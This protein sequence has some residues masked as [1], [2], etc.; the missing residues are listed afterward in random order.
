MA[1]RFA[2]DRKE[3]KLFEGLSRLMGAVIVGMSEH[4]VSAP[5]ASYLVRNQSRF[6]F[7]EEFAYVPI[8]EMVEI[9]EG[10]GKEMKMSVHC[11][12]NGC[13]YSSQALHYL[14][15]PKALKEDLCMLNF[16]QQYYPCRSYQHSKLGEEDFEIDDK[17]HPG[18]KRQVFRKRAVPALGQFS[19]W[20]IPDSSTLG[21]DI[22]KLGLDKGNTTIKQYCHAILVLFHPFRKVE[23]LKL[24]GSYFRKFRQIYHSGVPACI[25]DMLGNV[26]MA[27]NTLQMPPSCDPI[28]DQTTQYKSPLCEKEED[29]EDDNNFFDSLLSM[30]SQHGPQKKSMKESD[31]CMSLKSLRKAGAWG[32]GFFDL[33][34]VESCLTP[35]TRGHSPFVTTVKTTAASATDSKANKD[36]ASYHDKPSMGELMRLTYSNSRRRTDTSTPG[37]SSNSEVTA[38]G[39]AY[40]IIKWSWRKDLSMDREQ[41]LAFQTATAAFVL[42]Y[43]DEAEVDNGRDSGNN[44]HDFILEKLKLQ[45]LA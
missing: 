7:S 19:H 28:K 2:E 44:H 25:R 36:S 27:Y 8:R 13:F 37:G 1:R 10:N 15:R 39:T 5:M 17:E 9:L 21:G 30:L 14:H 22:M 45:R 20:N 40:S 3:G 4:V 34:N 33:P 29:E 43:Y 41:Q 26:Q 24:E 16:F 11:H 42:T 23:E 31:L 38:D 18:Y 35:Q 32:C 12:E 6:R